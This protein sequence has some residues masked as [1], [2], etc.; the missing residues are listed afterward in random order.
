[1][2]IIFV[3]FCGT[4][5]S[6]CKAI[7]GRMFIHTEKRITVKN[8]KLSKRRLPIR[9]PLP[10]SFIIEIFIFNTSERSVGIKETKKSHLKTKGVI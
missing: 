4:V 1:M 3:I 9:Y 6:S 7:S 2:V 10:F 8:S 5:E